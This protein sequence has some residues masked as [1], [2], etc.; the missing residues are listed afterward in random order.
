MDNK[1]FDLV[2]FHNPLDV[3]F[4]IVYNKEIVRTIPAGGT[5]Q[6]VSMWAMAGEIDLV[7]IL[8]RRDK[9][10]LLNK[11][12]RAQYRQKVILGV[13]GSLLGEQPS[14]NELA[15][16]LLQKAAE[17]NSPASNTQAWKFDPLTGKPIESQQSTPQEPMPEMPKPKITY[18]NP[19]VNAVMTGLSAQGT[20]ALPAQDMTTDEAPVVLDKTNV[21]KEQVVAWIRATLPV[22]IDLPEV[23]TQIDAMTV[24]QLRKEYNYDALA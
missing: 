8:M 14:Q 18:A 5:M 22:N 12:A 10:S 11:E 1:L 6:I 2:T 9:V 23:K 17:K 3:P 16:Q 15:N 4:Q 20:G 19:E 7:N 13:E 21:S 24:E